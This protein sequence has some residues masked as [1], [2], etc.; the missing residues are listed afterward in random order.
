MTWGTVSCTIL[1]ILTKGGRAR[2][3]GRSRVPEGESRRDVGYWF[4]GAGHFGAGHFPTFSVAV[5][6]VESFPVF[7][8]LLVYF[9]FFESQ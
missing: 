8:L 5:A 1:T 2:E 3:G 9:A 6:G 7:F 4:L